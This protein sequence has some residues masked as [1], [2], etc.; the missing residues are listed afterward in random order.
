M[1]PKERNILEIK[2]FVWK[3]WIVCK[4]IEWFHQKTFIFSKMKI[5][6]IFWVSIENLFKRK[7]FQIFWL[8]MFQQRFFECIVVKKFYNFD[9]KLLI[10][11]LLL[12][13]SFDEFQS[14]KLERVNKFFNIIFLELYI[15][16]VI[17][18]F[19]SISLLPLAE[20][21]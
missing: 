21:C 17:S 8:T 19:H 2:E 13:M 6:G 4:F 12:L 1:R 5:G 20:S 15:F 3:F 10:N 11:C 14:S 16:A 9:R 7:I 18:F